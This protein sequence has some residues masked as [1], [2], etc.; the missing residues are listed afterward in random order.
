MRVLVAGGKDN[1][2]PGVDKALLRSGHEVPIVSRG[3]RPGRLRPVVRRLRGDRTDRAAFARSGHPNAAIALISVTKGDAGSTPR[4]VR[5]MRHL[6]PTATVYPCGGPLPSVLAAEARPRRPIT[7]DGRNKRE[8]ADDMVG[9]A[10]AQ[11]EVPLATLKSAPTW[12]LGI[13]VIRHVG[14]GRCWPDRPA[15]IGSAG[16]TMWRCGHAA[17]A[18]VVDAA[19]WAMLADIAWLEEQGLLNDARPDDAEDRMSAGRGR[20]PAEGGTPR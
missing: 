13:V 9:T 19:V 3:R 17:D 15:L 8:E 18:G 20:L 5:G 12:R 16:E 2:S 10:H 11:G 14:I 1:I 7:D 4:A 6:I